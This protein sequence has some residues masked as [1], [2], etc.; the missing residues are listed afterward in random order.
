MLLTGTIVSAAP[1][2]P[3]TTAV[4]SYARGA[5]VGDVTAS[6]GTTL[7]DGDRLSTDEQGWLR[8]GT[9]GYQLQLRPR[10]AVTLWEFSTAGPG[11]ALIE[12]AIG[13][14]DLS[15]TKTTPLAVLVQGARFTS[16]AD[17]P[18]MATIEIRGAREIHVYVKRGTLNLQY[19]SE[20]ALLAESRSY[21]LLLDPTDRE[22]ALAQTLG[23]SR[24]DKKRLVRRPVFLLILIAAAIGVGIPVLMHSP[25]SPH[26]VS[27]DRH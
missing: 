9:P 12:M 15:A 24:N 22:I 16:V 26:T 1:P 14:I 27:Q 7:Y 5:Q 17:K 19:Q 2:G 4:I 13:A 21:A 11:G 6:A 18:M 3:P 23:D 25:E 8:A 10:T 20:T